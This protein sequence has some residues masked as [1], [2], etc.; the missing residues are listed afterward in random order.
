MGTRPLAHRDHDS[1]E[2]TDR[3]P[4]L[5]AP[6]SAP[7]SAPALDVEGV[8]PVPVAGR[9]VGLAGVAG[10]A[11]LAG[12]VQT[13][14]VVG[15]AGDPQEAEADQV[16]HAVVDLLRGRATGTAPSMTDGAA[17][18]DP[19]DDAVHRHPSGLSALQ[20]HGAATTTSTIG[21]AGGELA[22]DVESVLQAATGGGVPL[23]ENL[24]TPIEH[25][26]GADFS[27]V[28]IHTGPQ[29]AELN[30]SM[31]ALAFTHGRDIY[32]RD[33][34][35][36]PSTEAGLQLLAHELTHTVQQG[37][38]PSVQRHSTID[39]AH[40]HEHEHAVRPAFDAAIGVRRSYSGPI[41]QR[42]AAFEHYLLGQL[43]P[44]ELAKIPA[45][46]KI[47]DNPGQK[48]NVKKGHG[49]GLTEKPEDKAKKREVKHLIDQEMDRLWE[50][51]S[52]PEA[53][54]AKESEK[55]QVTRREDATWNVPIVVLPCANGESIVVS[56]S[57]MNTMPDLFGNPEAIAKTPKAKVLALLQGVRQQLYIELSNL[58]KELFGHAHNDLHNTVTVDDDFDTAQGPRAQQGTELGEKAFGAYE[59]R[60]EMQVNS[61]T[62]R[63]GD[64]HEQ[65]F[66]AL[67][68][69]ACHFAPE[70]W[71][72]W[73][74]Y[75]DDALASAR[76]S[77][78]AKKLAAGKG[79]TPEEKEM[80]EKKAADL[81]NE[82]LINNSFGEHYLQDS[83]AS[84]HLIDKTKIMQWFTLWLEKNGKGLGSGAT[85]KAQWDMTVHAAG[86]DLTSNPQALHDR[87]V[88]NDL[89]SATE[90]ANEVGMDASEEMKFMMRWRLLA[91][92]DTKMRTLTG[93][94][95]AANLGVSAL[96]AEQNMEILARKKFAT[97]GSA[98][99][100][101]LSTAQA[102]AADPITA[103][104]VLSLGAKAL[105][106]HP[107]T[108]TKGVTGTAGQMSDQDAE[109]AASEFNLVSYNALMSNAYI[110]AAT[111]FFHDKFCKEGL[112]V[113]SGAGVLLGRIYGD[114]NMLNAGG[115]FGL[116]YAAETSRR[117][118]SAVFNLINGGQEMF[119]TDSIAE[120]FPT[121][122]L[123]EG[124]MLPIEK[125]NEALRVKGEAGWFAKAQ[126]NGALTVYK[127][128]NGISAKGALDI[129]MLTSGIRAEIG[130]LDGLPF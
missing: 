4:V 25:A 43:Q 98:G 31:S 91:K 109:E 51:K 72:Q 12:I 86:M 10:R 47:K 30:R 89:G 28:R 50:F 114:A 115:Q 87:G 34:M 105:A 88:R 65:Y 61:A 103:T 71:A 118:R 67:E 14:V 75:H 101:T 49:G 74:R 22:G 46:R 6:E 38:A 106:T 94:L 13:K 52:D 68:R 23:A 35:P 37:A 102:E 117:S 29:P 60:T 119:T 40:Q 44:S 90:A 110:Q 99:R 45:V 26:M 58:R 85:A 121:E 76:A 100:F 59:K 113:K 63:K 126:S 48:A 17:E 36:D 64:E 8:H 39:T 125:F 84:G 78:M 55:G 16:A 93:Q 32:F 9:A 96:V 11:G 5:S 7:E 97:K 56:Y 42:H 112:E 53:L 21:L 19:T 92:N 15:A 20:R 116:E 123:F 27:T 79:K 129:D 83:F 18:H 69:N 82:A 3:S 62:T 73:R 24:R 108:A 122:V 41:I 107:Y 80:L 120:R 57:E 1:E 66:A 33:G 81:A 124:D 111:K 104:G 127:A 95:A 128:K 77:A 2:L 54:S 130:P 70:S